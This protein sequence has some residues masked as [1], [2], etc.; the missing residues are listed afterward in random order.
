M[1]L[2][3]ALDGNMTMTNM[4]NTDHENETDY[5]LLLFPILLLITAMC[6]NLLLICGIIY[7]LPIIFIPWMVFYALE[8]SA[9]WIAGFFLLFGI[10]FY[11]NYHNIL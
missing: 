2:D 8:L 6:C 5:L 11:F 4:T 10:S 7:K 3:M 1:I 9:S